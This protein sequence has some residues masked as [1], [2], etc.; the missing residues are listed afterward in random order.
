MHRM[1]QDN[2]IKTVVEFTAAKFNHCDLI[3]N[4]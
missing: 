4:Q 3:M 2:A 1:S